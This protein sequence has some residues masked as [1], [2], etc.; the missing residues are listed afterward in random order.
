MEMAA[1]DHDRRQV[2]MKPRRRDRYLRVDEIS[3]DDE[4][5][6]ARIREARIAAGYLTQRA[7]SEALRVTQQSVWR[8]ER[9]LSRPNRDVLQA[10]CSVL[11]VTPA[12]VMHGTAAPAAE[13][14]SQVEEAVTEG[15]WHYLES[16]PMDAEGRRQYGARMIAA[17]MTILRDCTV[18]PSGLG[19]HVFL[20]DLE[21][22]LQT[23]DEQTG[24][25]SSG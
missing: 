14:P 10:M 18:A 5:R 6:G 12:W 11:R 7:F 17:A 19:M 2:Q 15:V 21:R 22:A 24:G 4:A 16:R 25:G 23:A 20:H 3:A 8:F 13:Q 9:G 1:T